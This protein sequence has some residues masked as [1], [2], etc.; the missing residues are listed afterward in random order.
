[1][2]QRYDKGSKW[3][4]QHHADAILRL[5]G[6]PGVRSCRALAAELV[7]SRQLPDGLVEAVIDGH[8][9]P[10]LFLIEISTF[11]DN[12]VPDQ[13]LDDLA[14]TYLDRRAV[15]EI[16]T[17]VLHPKGNVRVDGRLELASPLGGT[18]LAG[19]WRVVELWTVPAEPLLAD[20]D[21][22]VIPWLPLM[23]FA[24]EPAALLKR[25]DE[26]LSERAA[27][28]ELPVLQA[29]ATILAGLRYDESLFTN[30]FRGRVM[31]LLENSSVVKVLMRKWEAIGR[32][33]S[34]LDALE[35]RFDPL[36]QTVTDRVRATTEPDRL[37]AL[38]VAAVRCESLAE[39]E[40][41]LN[42]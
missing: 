31:D 9:R 22:G 36:P 11:P 24:G 16:I 42:G 18:Q 14:L 7:Q 10:V 17:L 6:V 13:L 32:Q 8:D 12:R 38:T 2:R 19:R 26:L 28:V 5:A 4:L 30:L 34:I 23:Q 41:A 21:P 29:I 40:A 27:E 33:T 39:F 35:A 20:P 37:K 3:L 15:P 25:C 1:V